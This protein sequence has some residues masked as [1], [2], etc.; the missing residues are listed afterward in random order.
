MKR[1]LWIL[2]FA[3]VISACKKGNN[4]KP[5]PAANG[6]ISGSV[7]PAKGAALRVTATTT[8]NGQ[9]VFY[10]ADAATDENGNYKFSNLPAGTYTL[11]FSPD[12]EYAGPSD[13]TIKVTAGNNTDAGVAAFISINT[14]TISG[15]VTPAGTAVS[16]SA[17]LMDPYISRTLTAI[18]DAVTGKF[19]ITN[20]PA[21]SYTI[22]IK[23][24][25]NYVS[26]IG[27]Q[28]NI[29]TGQQ[30]DAG[31]FTIITKA[32]AFPLN[33]NF[34]GKDISVPSA[35]IVTSYSNNNL[36]IA[37]VRSEGGMPTQLGNKSYTLIIKLR[38]ITE[39]GTYECSELSS[40]VVTYTNESY[41]Y[42][43]ATYTSQKVGAHATVVITAIDPVAHTVTGT[44]TGTLASTSSLSTVTEELTNGAFTVRYY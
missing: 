7:S 33:Y 15:V 25:A 8:V 23:A 26:A 42:S 3:V 20:V 34:G 14:A 2:L 18:P 6:S 44:V 31:S 32:A 5:A 40:S 30:A 28:V 22:Y 10:N 43:A 24:A 16:V 36:T 41:G 9:V 19:T 35:S 29:T 39:P 13:K 27:K 12:P 17:T 4:L 37:S 38:D 1:I 11:I 21:G